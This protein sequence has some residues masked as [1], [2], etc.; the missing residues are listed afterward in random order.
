MNWSSLTCADQFRWLVSA[1]S[2]TTMPSFINRSRLVAGFSW[3][4]GRTAL[5]NASPSPWT[6]MEITV[7]FPCFL[8]GKTGPLLLEMLWGLWGPHFLPDASESILV[9][10]SLS[11]LIHILAGEWSL[12]T[13]I[14]AFPRRWTHYGLWILRLTLRLLQSE[15]YWCG[16]QFVHVSGLALTIEHGFSHV[17]SAH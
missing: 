16:S 7:S 13:R 8:A 2:S 4:V 10:S 17:R 15:M 9:D 3:L 5:N 12:I 1:N 6:R 11:S 14:S